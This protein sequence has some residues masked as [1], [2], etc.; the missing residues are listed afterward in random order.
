MAREAL[1]RSAPHCRA[2]EPAGPSLRRCITGALQH[3]LRDRVRLVRIS[4]REHE[5]GTW[6]LGHTSLDVPAAGESF[7][8]EQQIA[9]GIPIPCGYLHRG[10]ISSPAGGGHWLIVVGITPSHVIVHDPL[11]EADLVNGT[12]LGGTARFCRY[13]LANDRCAGLRLRP[14]LDGGGRGQRLGEGHDPKGRFPHRCGSVV[15]RR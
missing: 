15:E 10:P 5:K 9:A 11:G 1:V 3:H 13:C 8:L 2:G 4:R 6:P 12:T 7:L 14:A